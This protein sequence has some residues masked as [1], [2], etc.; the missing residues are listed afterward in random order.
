MEILSVCKTSTQKNH[1]VRRGT[2]IMC[3]YS[4]NFS[5]LFKIQDDGSGHLAHTNAAVEGETFFSF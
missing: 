3:L 4:L 1:L 5:P 2:L